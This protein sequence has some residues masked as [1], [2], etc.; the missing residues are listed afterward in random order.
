MKNASN[1]DIDRYCV[2][3]TAGRNTVKKKLGKN[4]TFS[5]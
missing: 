5:R 3:P 1:A 4:Q 2:T